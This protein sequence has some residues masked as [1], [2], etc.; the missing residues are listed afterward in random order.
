MILGLPTDQAVGIEPAPG[1]NRNTVYRALAPEDLYLKLF[2]GDSASRDAAG[3]AFAAR[4]LGRTIPAPSILAHGFDP[5]RRVA[6]LVSAAVP[7]SRLDS[8]LPTGRADS[9]RPVLA[10]I[11]QALERLSRSADSARALAAGAENLAGPFSPDFSPTEWLSRH[12]QGL[13]RIVVGVERI[14]T[15]PLL[16]SL[17]GNNVIVEACRGVPSLSAFIDFEGA[18]VG[19]S[20]FD[21][22]MLWYDL[23]RQGREDLA[24]VWFHLVRRISGARVVRGLIVN[25]AWLAAF[26]TSHAHP[27]WPLDAALRPLVEE[28]L[29]AMRCNA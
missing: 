27:E 1:P 15:A 20:G 22:A 9:L 23:L 24:E 12:D 17:S 16:G 28:R 19:P 8:L 26:R 25:A 13:A 3:E 7:G 4:L 29:T 11:A 14:G 21:Q 18:R 5:V 6:Y 10:D 2:H